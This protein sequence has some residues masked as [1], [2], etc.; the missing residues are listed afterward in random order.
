MFLLL[1]RGVGKMQFFKQLT[2]SRFQQ[3][4]LIDQQLMFI[5]VRRGVFLRTGESDVQLRNWLLELF[6]LCKFLHVGG[7]KLLDFSLVVVHH[8]TFEL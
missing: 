7:S 2:I 5:E 6:D 3:S 1:E 4:Y 8:V